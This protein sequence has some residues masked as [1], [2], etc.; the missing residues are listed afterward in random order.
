MLGLSPFQK[1]TTAMRM[2]AYG[3]PA[4]AVDAYVRIGENTLLECVKRFTKAIV[5]VF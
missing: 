1:A 4:D 3:I 2:L 5:D